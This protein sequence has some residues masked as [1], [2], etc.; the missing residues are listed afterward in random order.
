[1]LYKSQSLVSDGDP[2]NAQAGSSKGGAA[3][4]RVRCARDRASLNSGKLKAAV[5]NPLDNMRR[6]GYLDNI[7]HFQ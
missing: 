6:N 5:L 7:R 3:F 2:C 4:D 1:M